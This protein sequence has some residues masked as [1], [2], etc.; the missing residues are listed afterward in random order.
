MKTKALLTLVLIICL[1]FIFSIDSRCLP[2]SVAV[3]K[4]GEIKP[5][6]DALA[7]F[8]EACKAKTT[9][10]NVA[11]EIDN[12]TKIVKKIMEKNPDL[13]LAIGTKA[14]I[15]AKQEI[16][17]IP[18]VFLMV[19]RP[20]KYGL[21]GKNITGVS[22]NIPAKV[23][24]KALISILP[25]LKKI[26][27]IYN[28]AISGKAIEI[29]AA[30]AQDLGL[31]L[32]AIKINSEKEVPQA[33]R[34]LKGNIDA[35]WMVIDETVVNS[36]STP[37]IILF[38]IRNKMPLMGLSVRFAQDGAL[39]A[40]QSDYKNMGRQSGKIANLILESRSIDVMPIASPEKSGLVLNLKTAKL[41]DIDI[42]PDVIKKASRIIK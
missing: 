13:I 27:V 5:Y 39:L 4:S 28:P 42:P 11:G 15:L 3:I 8:K 33:L 31:E 29:A 25:Q 40:L 26:G 22:L 16:S 2:D 6:Q 32:F 41:I 10:Y 20:E 17:N 1:I 36:Q 35:M 23:Q 12:E 14:A 18:M 37:H 34:T 19:S 9:E 7:G 24:F 38:T 21:T 30:D